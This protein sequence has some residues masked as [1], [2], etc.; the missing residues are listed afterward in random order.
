MKV[1]LSE[2]SADALSRCESIQTWAVG[3]TM[4]RGQGGMATD[5]RLASTTSKPSSKA[6]EVKKTVPGNKF[7][8]KKLQGKKGK[9]DQS[10]K[11]AEESHLDLISDKDV[12]Y[13]RSAAGRK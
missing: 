11:N 1:R 12:T 8:K 2:V 13:A 9:G 7:A 6:V 10:T 3:P 4:R 5:L